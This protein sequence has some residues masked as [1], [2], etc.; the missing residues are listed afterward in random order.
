METSADNDTTQLLQVVSLDQV[1]SILTE[2][3]ELANN[4]SEASTNAMNS[5]SSDTLLENSS[6]NTATSA[7]AQAFSQISSSSG[8][9][10]KLSKILFLI[11]ENVPAS[12]N[13][14]NN[15]SKS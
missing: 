14:S 9:S 3:S 15:H 5:S 10:S 12:E 6:S 4:E 11:F 1:I 8:G 13:K 2:Q 7:F